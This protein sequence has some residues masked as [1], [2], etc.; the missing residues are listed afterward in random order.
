MDDSLFLFLTPEADKETKYMTVTIPKPRIKPGEF[1]IVL[2][3]ETDYQTVKE[4]KRIG[5]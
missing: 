1:Q 3:P 2:D 5:K 4:V